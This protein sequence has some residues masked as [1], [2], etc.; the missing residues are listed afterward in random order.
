MVVVA[1]ALRVVVVV[2]T[3]G[4]WRPP[5][6]VRSKDMACVGLALPYFLHDSR[7]SRATAVRQHPIFYTTAA[8]A[9]LFFRKTY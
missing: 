5:C 6:G 9:D 2:C 7:D 4:G 1:V 3:P 8:T